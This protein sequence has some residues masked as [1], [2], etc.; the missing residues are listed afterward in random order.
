MIKAIVFDLDYT[1]YD[2]HKTLDLI[3]REHM[4]ERFELLKDVNEAVRI[5]KESDDHYAYFGWEAI[6]GHMV[7]CRLIDGTKYTHLDVKDFFWEYFAKIAVNFEGIEE[8]LS[9]LKSRGLKLGILTNGGHE[10]QSAKISLIG[11]EKYFDEILISWD[12]PYNKPEKEIFEL[13]ANRLGVNT[14]ETVYVGDAP[15]NDIHGSRSAGC[16]PAWV[17]TSGVWP[18]EFD[19]IEKPQIVLEHLLDTERVLLENGLV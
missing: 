17:K 1:L 8:M 14:D 2:R 15:L 12:T 4:S 11:L 18:K 6:Y 13:M 16:I 7:K 3:V 19:C 5:V 9:S 10:L